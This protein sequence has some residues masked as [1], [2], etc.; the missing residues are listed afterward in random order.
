M[1]E[2]D[3][4]RSKISPQYPLRLFVEPIEFLARVQAIRSM[5][6]EHGTKGAELKPSGEKLLISWI[7]GIPVARRTVAEEPAC[8]GIPIWYAGKGKI[9]PRRNLIAEDLPGSLNVARP[10][11]RA[12]ALLAGISRTSKD[13]DSLLIGGGSLPLINAGRVHQGISIINLIP[14]PHGSDVIAKA[15]AA[16]FR[17]RCIEPP[18]IHPFGKELVAYLIPIDLPALGAER[19][20]PLPLARWESVTCDLGKHTTGGIELLAVIAAEVEFRPD[21]NERVIVH[22]VQFLEHACRIRVACRVK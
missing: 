10:G 8:V 18:A 5:D 19:V 21:G 9:E 14:W 11:D 15:H 13:D 3:S 22:L 6:T 1:A 4:A 12:V 16:N 2:D 7:S 17:L 20:I